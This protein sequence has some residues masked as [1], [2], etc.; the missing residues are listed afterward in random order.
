[1]DD[2]IFTDAAS[3]RTCSGFHGQSSAGCSGQ[4]TQWWFAARPASPKPLA[5]TQNGARASRPRH[6]HPHLGGEAGHWLR[7]SHV[8][9]HAPHADLSGGVG[10]GH[11]PRPD[12]GWC[13]PGC[14]RGQDQWQAPALSPE[15]VEAGRDSLENGGSVSG[16]ART[17]GVSCTT[18]RAVRDGVY[19]ATL[20]NLNACCEIVDVTNPASP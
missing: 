3:G 4:G 9:A 20:H 8:P 17:F 13:G 14:G 1:M 11:D 2:R 18:V 16:A 12:Q 10:K 5:R 19:G 15:K 6:Q 7:Q